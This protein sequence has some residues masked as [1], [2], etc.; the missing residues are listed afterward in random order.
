[1]SSKV[2]EIVDNTNTYTKNTRP[3]DDKN[4]KK[5]KLTCEMM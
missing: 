2:I 1:M 4:V 3:I 5:L